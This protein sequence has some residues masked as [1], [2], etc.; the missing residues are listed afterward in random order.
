MV[1]NSPGS[2]CE[3]IARASR[4]GAAWGAAAVLFLAAPAAAQTVTPPTLSDYAVLG[5]G[6]VMIRHG[7]RVVSGA[8]GAVNGTVRLGPKARVTNAVAGPSVRLTAGSRTGRLFCHFVSGPPTLPL[9]NAFTD[10]LVDPMLLAPVPVVPGTSD[11]V[12]GPHTGSAP[13][14]S[15]SFAD[16][17]VGRGSTLQLYGGAYA[18]RSLRIGPHA[19]VVC[20]NECRIGVLGPVR[21]QR[22]ASLGAISPQRAGIARIDIAETGTAAL[23]ARSRANVAATIFAPAGDVVLGGLGAY[24]GV[25]VGRTVRIGPDATVRAA[26]AL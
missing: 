21:L 22:S 5:L 17:R 24:R 15:G 10:P 1:A 13:V 14:P 16:V 4:V 18:M 25:F 26:G 11:L 7:S 9:C 3:M 19:R 12:L 20:A 2:C 6:D 23:F 8:V